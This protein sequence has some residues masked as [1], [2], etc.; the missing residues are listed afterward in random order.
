[1]QDPCNKESHLN[2]LIP[3]AKSD[4]NLKDNL[5]NRIVDVIDLDADDSV[6]PDEHKIES[7]AKPFGNCDDT[8]IPGL[9]PVIVNMITKGHLTVFVNLSHE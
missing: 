1:M 4:L 5:H 3:E 2:W 6:F 8:L 7:S 9:S